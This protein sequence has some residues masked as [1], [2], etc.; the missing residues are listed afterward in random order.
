MRPLVMLLLLGTDAGTVDA[1]CVT[2]FDADAGRGTL[3]FSNTVTSD[4]ILDLK[5]KPYEEHKLLTC[6]NGATPR[7]V[8]KAGAIWAICDARKAGKK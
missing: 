4:Y 2:T 3:C 7:L 6:A 8:T 5:P 1:G